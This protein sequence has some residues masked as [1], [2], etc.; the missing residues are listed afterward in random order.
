LQ[1]HSNLSTKTE[2]SVYQEM[3]VWYNQ[4]QD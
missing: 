1:K 4:Q 3:I 2:A